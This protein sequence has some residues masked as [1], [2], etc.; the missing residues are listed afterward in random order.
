MNFTSGRKN[1]PFYTIL[2]LVRQSQKSNASVTSRET[3]SC[4]LSWIAEIT[5][6]IHNKREPL[7]RYYGVSY[8]DEPKTKGTGGVVAM[9]RC[10][11]AA[12]K[13]LPFF[14]CLL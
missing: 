5:A 4:S 11:V 13:P 7:V 6:H 12:R 1:Q 9:S 3:L 10:L 14:N 2:S 8:K